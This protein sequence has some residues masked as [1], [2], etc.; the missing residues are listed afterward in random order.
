M[1]FTVGFTRVLGKEVR[2][3]SSKHTGFVFLRQ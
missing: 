2:I 1:G 3:E